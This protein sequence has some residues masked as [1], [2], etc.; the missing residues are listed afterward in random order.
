[1]SNP[2]GLTRERVAPRAD[3][4]GTHGGGIWKDTEYGVGTVIVRAGSTVTGNT[5]DD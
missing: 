3:R 1:M 4:P 5:P 2:D